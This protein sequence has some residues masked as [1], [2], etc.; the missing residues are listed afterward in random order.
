MKQSI[1]VL[2]ACTALSHLAVL[3]QAPAASPQ[4]SEPAAAHGADA[5]FGMEEPGASAAGALALPGRAG[6]ASPAP[7]GG[8]RVT[9]KHELSARLHDPQALS[10]NRS[11]VRVEVEQHFL[12]NFY[13]HA[14][15]IGTAFWRRDHRARAGDRD[16][17]FTESTIRD[18]Y[19]QFSLGSTSIK[20][21][22]QM[23]I[24]GESDAGAITDVISPRNFTE[25]FF[26]SLEEARLSQFMVTLDQYS[27]VGDFSLFY[28]PSARFN[29]YPEP[30]TAY[31]LDP[32]GGAAQTRTDKHKLREYGV[33]WKKT[34]GN[35]DLALMAARLV[36]NDYAVRQEGVLADGRA[37]LVNQAQRFGMLGMTVSHA[38]DGFLLSSEVARKS[39]R[40]L[41]DP[42]TLQP[43][44]KD[45]IDTSLKV[46]YS[47]GGNHAVSVEA[48]NRHVHNWTAALAPAP[49]N[50]NSL[51]LS[52]SNTFFN[53]NLSAN[54]LTVY[55]QTHTGY[56][57][58][59]FM[60][61]KVNNRFT[62][63]LDAFYLGVKNRDNE[64]YP[65]RGQNSA[66]L[67]ALYQF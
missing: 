40:A 18:A 51:V 30:G 7:A 1:Q 66:V 32:F 50:A 65:Y 41:L 17:V 64:L 44:L 57:H 53:D 4:A 37:L 8:T 38:I 15:V 22:R 19:L 52:W 45:G 29:R 10:N 34:F 12:D 47:L 23:L 56:Q 35:T 13:V 20:A 31:Y 63:N 60:S 62:L 42:A 9:L 16:G 46:E 48:V 26:I 2:L 61:Y 49:R 28:T 36:D 59:L 5:V 58:S 55:N 39:P 11:S 54:W 43:V 67:R 25:L 21:G 24:W 27:P 33:R 3:A 14:D 6:P